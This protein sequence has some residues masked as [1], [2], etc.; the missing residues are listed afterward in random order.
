MLDVSSYATR[1]I[2]EKLFS[3][4]IVTKKIKKNKNYT[5]NTAAYSI[6]GPSAGLAYTL[7]G[8]LKEKTQ[9]QKGL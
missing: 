5:D 2:I 1:H 9:K 7:F 6:T 3:I 4:K 8:A